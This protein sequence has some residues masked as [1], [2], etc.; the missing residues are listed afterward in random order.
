[1]PPDRDDLAPTEAMPPVLP[2]RHE[3][4]LPGAVLADRYRI[5][6]LSGRGGMGE[7]YRADD[8]KIGQPV[9]LKFLSADVERDPDR[10]QRLLG[11]VRIARQVS[12]PNVCRVYDVVEFEGHH[13]I[14]MEYVDGEDLAALL[15][16]IGRLPQ[17][18]AIDL[19]RQIGAGLAA[20]HVQGIVHRDLKPANIMLDGRGRARITDFGLAAAAQAVRGQEAQWGTPAYMAPEQQAGEAIT[21]RT[22]V[23]ALGLVLFEMF[24]GRRALQ[25]S[26]KPDL[27]TRVEESAERPS[28]FVP[29]LDPAIDAAILKCIEKDP[30]RRPGSAVGL[31]ALLPGG[32][33]LDSALRAGETPSP[34]MVAA[35][36]EEGSLPSARAWGLFG[37]AL[38]AVVVA[39]F[40]GA[41]VTGLEQVSM[42]RSPDALRDRAREIAHLLGDDVPSRSVE[43]WFDL[44][45]GYLEWSLR[46]PHAPP[47]ADARPSP[48]RFNYRQ[49]L[50]PILPTRL[51][52]PTRRD[53]APSLRGDS[54]IALD[55]HGSLLGFWRLDRQLA[56]PDSG[57]T[58]PMD[59]SPLL[60]LT[61]ADVRGPR[62][63]EPLWTPDVPCDARAAWI[64]DDGGRSIRLEAAAW[65]GKPVWLR[66]IAPWERAERDSP[67]APRG[68]AGFALFVATALGLVIAFGAL[69]RHNLRLGRSDTRG[70]IRVGVAVFLCFGAAHWLTFRWAVDPFQIWRGIVRQ[71]Y[72]PALAAWLMY[73]GVE[74]FLRRRWPHRLVGWT[75]LLEGRFADPL[76]GREL[77]LGLLAGAGVGLAS[78]LPAAF[79]RGHDVSLLLSTLPLGRAADFW[80]STINVLGE[81]LMRALGAFGLLLLFRVLFRHDA[82]AWLGLGLLW[83]LLGLP[84]WNVS[85]IG[86]VSLAL[87]AAGFV[88][89]V[90]VGL[91]AAI[92]AVATTG[93]LTFCAPLTI[94][95]SRWYAWRTGVVAVLLLAIAVWG[96]RAVMGRRRILSAAMFEG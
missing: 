22:D 37:L 13:F 82:A 12:H 34:E 49:S 15:R 71:P 42:T 48:I 63:V 73:L 67:V 3:R 43:C 1:M 72:F 7:V 80:G 32:D 56:P 62:R 25:G 70:A 18:K 83:T 58:A 29:G 69:A 65:R 41:R 55:P 17:E 35:A 46:Q 94:D 4:F 53:P 27:G 2:H 31:L 23:Y 14:S 57:R 78:C 92:V 40:V 90:R 44:D 85:V 11:E 84:S 91:V 76:V 8:L 59:W 75:R 68:A 6:A 51:P 96:F 89:A 20:A 60:A 36:G 54:Y 86:W 33:P 5:V 45:D 30:M 64:E 95:F 52:W 28:S 87:S 38:L 39:I 88:L 21:P 66:T 61:G 93:L 77:L 79:E 47:L 50:G 26:A 74:P 16:R 9:A 19:A 81:G 24:T 10:L